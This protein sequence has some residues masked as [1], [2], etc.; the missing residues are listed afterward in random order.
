MNKHQIYVIGDGNN[1]RDSVDELLLSYRLDELATF[2]AQITEAIKTLA[3]YAI[4]N[5]NATIIISGGDDILFYVRRENYRK[6][7]IAKMASIYKEMT[8][9]T[10]SFGIG[11]TIE[12]ALVDLRRK[13]VG[14]QEP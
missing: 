8:S 12:K 13:K 6:E 11:E 3:E 9:A 10:I 5:M 4:R 1:T 7:Y 14:L 2:S